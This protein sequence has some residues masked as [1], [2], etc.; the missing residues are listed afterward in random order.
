MT[1]RDRTGDRGAME[2]MGRNIG[3]AAGRMAGRA[4]DVAAGMAAPLFRTA[5]DVLGGWWSKD[6]AREAARFD[7]RDETRWRAHYEGHA[8]ASGTSASGGTT[9][10]GSS[11]AGRSYEDVRPYYQ[12]GHTASR[13]PEYASRNFEEIEPDLERVWDEGDVGS[14]PWPEARGYVEFGYRPADR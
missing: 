10:G 13:N 2:E 3:E 7:E 5:A 14:D 11:S 8:G 4:A 12:L 6:D 9:A 1:N